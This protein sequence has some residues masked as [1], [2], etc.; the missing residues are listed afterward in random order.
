MTITANFF[1]EAGKVGREP[2][3][4]IDVTLDFCDLING[5]APCTASPAAGGECFNTY[6]TCQDP[7][8]FGNDSKTYSFVSEKARPEPGDGVT[9]LYPVI[10]TLKVA[11]TKITPSK[12]LGQIASA[13]AT[14]KDF[15]NSDI[16]LDK[17]VDT[18]AYIATD[19]G[20]YFGKLLARNPYWEGRPMAVKFR[21]GQES[22]S[23]AFIIDRFERSAKGGKVSLV[24]KDPLKLTSGLKSQCPAAN[25][26][27][28]S[29]AIVGASTTWTVSAAHADQYP[30][31]A[32][33]Y[34]LENEIIKASRSGTT[35]TIVTR[36]TWSTTAADHAT[37]TTI[38]LCAAWE[39]VDLD[40]IIYDLLVNYAGIPSGYIPT[41]DWQAEFDQW[42]S[43][44]TLDNIV[45]EPAAVEDLLDQILIETGTN[46]WWDG[47]DEE[48][49][50]KADVPVLPTDPNYPPVALNDRQN[51]IR[52]SLEYKIDTKQRVSQFWFYANRRSY[53]EDE[54]KGSNYQDLVIRADVTGEGALA[55]GS[56]TIRKIFCRWITDSHAG[57]T[58]SRYLARFRH[59]PAV[60]TFELD[61]QDFDLRTGQ[62]FVLQSQAMQLPTGGNA[63]VE[64][65]CVSVDYDFQAQKLK[66]EG[67]QFRYQ[68]GDDG[69]GGASRAA[70]VAATGANDY[71]SATTLEK[72]RAYVCDTSTLK[73]S[74]GD[75]PYT[76]I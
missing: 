18:R 48:I 10:E 49:K 32:S 14:L 62:H 61:P 39:A 42:L 71:T 40:D 16:G 64:F 51:I 76:V 15:T 26:G 27:V 57:Q 13:T 41:A 38:Q 56:K 50:F 67:L 12:G 7:A 9:P 54:E 68:T 43:D 69:G 2:T 73:L 31:A 4:Q 28:T 17:Y 3:T 19:Q 1:E 44:F 70:I 55:Y 37:G 35:F 29:S 60:V 47:F 11:P 66:V 75:D 58:A 59:S 36:G 22:A 23:Q 72:T 34:R 63:T 46:I 45:S 25:D 5:T 52:D 6:A 33:Y 53:I 30:T 74:N 24:G 65:D 21:Y 20:T 8:N